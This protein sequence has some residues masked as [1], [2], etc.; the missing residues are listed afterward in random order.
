MRRLALLLLPLTLSTVL[1]ARAQTVALDVCNTGTIEIDVF[2]SRDGALSSSHLEPSTCADVAKGATA[3]MLETYV[4]LAFADA[5]GQWGAPR[6]FDGVPDMGVREIPPALALG[7]AARGQA[8]PATPRVLTASSQTTT[9]RH[10]SAVVTLPLQLLFQPSIPQ[11]SNVVRSSSTVGFVGGQ[12][13]RERTYE[14]VCERF[15]YTLTVDAYADSHEA[16][17]GRLR[18]RGSFEDYVRETDSFKEPAPM[19]W[20]EIAADRKQRETTEPLS[21]NDLVPAFKRSKTIVGYNERGGAVYAG[22][23]PKAIKVRGTVSAVELRRQPVD[24]TTTVTVAEINF[25]ESPLAAGKP[26]PEFNVC[27]TRLDALQEV[28]GADY[29]TSLIGKM[30]EVQGKPRGVCWGQAGEIE[31]FL[32]RQVRPVDATQFAARASAAAP[33]TPAAATAPAAAAPLTQSLA[34]YQPSW[35][36][37]DMR[38]WGT[39]SR[40]VRRNVNGEPY[41]YLYFKESPDSTVVACSRDDRWIL[42]LLGLDDFPSLVGKTVEYNG[43]VGGQPCTEHGAS[44]WIGE[45][46]QL[47]PVVG[48][49]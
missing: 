47:R 38:V 15:V 8:A 7:F 24:A 1:P 44:L 25:R 11:C 31:F 17:L 42:A 22:T 41:L 3:E 35:I 20:A 40:F 5:H 49:R 4:G 45:R 2:V 10:G 32:A 9:V 6:R 39:V 23:M 43:K 12:E 19:N 29:R 14:E 48:T 37:H 16:G 30:I 34:G 27:T 21:W 13:Q 18:T 26:Y 28:F 33:A 46:D 36:G